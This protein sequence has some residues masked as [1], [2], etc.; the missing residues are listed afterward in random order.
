MSISW[1]DSSNWLDHLFLDFLDD[2]DSPS[3]GEREIT[4]LYHIPTFRR[5]NGCKES[6]ETVLA[7]LFFH[8]PSIWGSL[9]W[10]QLVA[11]LFLEKIAVQVIHVGYSH[12]IGWEIR[13][14]PWNVH[15][16]YHG[17]TGSSTVPWTN[18]VIPGVP[19]SELAHG[20]L[21]MEKVWKDG[22]KKLGIWGCKFPICVCVSK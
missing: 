22:D 4:R 18:S 5:N 7:H 15:W 16:F 13:R 1:V 12:Q 19:S 14:N 21:N 9:S 20:H 6:E 10:H 11:V 3:K 8:F 2:G 17:K